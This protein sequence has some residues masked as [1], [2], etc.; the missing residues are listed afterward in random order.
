MGARD[1]VMAF[2]PPSASVK[3][4]KTGNGARRSRLAR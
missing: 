1:G 4:G 3:G 2:Y